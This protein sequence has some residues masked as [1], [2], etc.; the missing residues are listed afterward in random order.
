M[1]GGKGDN[2]EGEREKSE[3]GEKAEAKDFIRARQRLEKKKQV[4]RQEL[5]CSVNEYRHIHHVR[6]LPISCWV[7]LSEGQAG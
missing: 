5:I 6:P 1:R 7:L 3:K 4:C 2:R